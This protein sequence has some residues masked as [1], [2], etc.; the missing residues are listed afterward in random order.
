MNGNRRTNGHSPLRD[1][2]H[3]FHLRPDRRHFARVA[4]MIVSFMLMVLALGGA[5]QFLLYVLDRGL[6][7]VG[8]Q[9]AVI[10][11]LLYFVT[12]LLSVGVSLL[13]QREDVGNVVIPVMYDVYKLAVSGALVYL[14]YEIIKRLFWQAYDVSR[15]LGYVGFLVGGVLLLLLLNR[16]SETKKLR[17][18]GGI[19]LAMAMVHLLV[20]FAQYSI[21]QSDR[22]D[23]FAADLIILGLMTLSGVLMIV[24][25]MFSRIAP[26]QVVAR[27]VWRGNPRQPPGSR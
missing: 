16:F 18:H 7:E 21:Q 23:F 12:L 5:G 14:Y 15:F 17:W 11:F 8:L 24:P 20:M 10:Q 13:G 2:S 9:R 22:G 19:L 26:G 25:G 3:P 6:M 1:S 4:A 27:N